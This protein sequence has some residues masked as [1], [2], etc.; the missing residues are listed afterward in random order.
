MDV[1][2]Q[3]RA[4]T[5]LTVLFGIAG[6]VLWRRRARR[7]AASVTPPPR[8]T[9]W[10]RWLVPEVSDAP[11]RVLQSARLTSRASV[12]VVRWD[13][14]EWLIGCTDR[15]L[16]V[17][18]QRSHP[19]GGRAEPKRSAST[20]A[21]QGSVETGGSQRRAGSERRTGSEP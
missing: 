14:T 16:T 19:T 9:G 18:G 6:A 12:H 5:F 21:N 17:I 3:V 4:F 13:D 20:G 1:W 11:L 15:E 8:V 2:A 10:L 7:S